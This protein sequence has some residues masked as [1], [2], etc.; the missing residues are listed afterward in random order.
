MAS[1]DHAQLSA[2]A[3]TVEDSSTRVAELAERL[4]D[5]NTSEAASAL[6]EAERS[7]QMA[8]RALDRAR[9]HLPT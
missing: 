3:A 2:I 6:Y 9:R 8:G 1:L 5:G 4:H 7:L